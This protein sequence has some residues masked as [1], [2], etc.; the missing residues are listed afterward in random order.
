MKP[1]EKLEMC[2]PKAQWLDFSAMQISCNVYTMEDGYEVKS[3]TIPLSNYLRAIDMLK[4]AS[5]LIKRL[6]EDLE[7]TK[8]TNQ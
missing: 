7:L 4:M 2:F 6:E 5:I 1:S 3:H 8:Q